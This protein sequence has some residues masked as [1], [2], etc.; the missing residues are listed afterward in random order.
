MKQSFIN[1]R[2]VYKANLIICFIRFLGTMTNLPIWYY[3]CFE[4]PDESSATIN[5]FIFLQYVEVMTKNVD[6]LSSFYIATLSKEFLLMALMNCA[7][8]PPIKTV[9]L[10]RSTTLF[11]V[12]NGPEWI[13]ISWF[14]EWS[15][16][17]RFK[18]Y[19]LTFK[20]NFAPIIWVNISSDVLSRTF[21]T[22]MTDWQLKFFSCKQTLCYWMI[23]WLSMKRFI[24]NKLYS[25]N[26]SI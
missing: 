18:N 17:V 25:T 6:F 19:L 15:A 1:A 22:N 4:E 10:L 13:K 2:F 20:L 9:I 3:D 8:L 7:R 14:Y 23:I 12:V 21:L 5:I 26:Y 16:F 24:L 11:S